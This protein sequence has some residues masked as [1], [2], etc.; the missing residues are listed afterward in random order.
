MK[1]IKAMHSV[2]G[3]V[4]AVLF[5]MW[6]ATG[7]V[8]IYHPYPRLDDK[9]QNHLS[10]TVQ[11]DSL[12]SLSYYTDSLTRDTI[13]SVSISQRLG[14]TLIRVST[15]DSA[16]TF[17]SDTTQAKHKVTFSDV[18]AVASRWVDAAPVR[19][20]TLNE[21]TQWVLYERYERAMPIYKFT[22]DDAEGHQLFISGKT[23][24]AQ[25]LTTCS[26]RIW[27][28]LGAIP[29]KF[30]Y[31]CIRKDVDLWK[32]VIT[33]G[34]IICLL[35]ALTGFM[36]GLSIQIRSCRRKHRLINPFKKPV[37]RWHHVIGL[38]FG[39]FIIGWGISGSLAMQKVPKWL[40]P[41][42]K[43]YSMY[44]PDIWEGD[45]L[46]LQ[47][48]RL[49]YRKVLKA[50]PEVKRIDLHVVGNKP[51]YVVIADS[52]EVYIDASDTVPQPLEVTAKSVTDAMHR[53]YG[54][55]TPVSVQL[56]TEYDEY[57]MA[58]YDTRPPLPVYK[59]TVADSD[60]STYYIG[61]D[62]DY[63]RYFNNNKKA[64]KWLFGALHYLNIKCIVS[65]PV[66]WHTCIW[67]LCFAGMAVSFTGIVLGVR[68]I[69]RKSKRI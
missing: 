47:T 18:E 11:T 51:V 59:V 35:A 56:M 25:Q 60:G 14:Q 2:T 20:D 64:R 55:E 17:C 45:S 65:H 29:H 24:E 3:T 9:L 28:W 58:S 15:A 33:T 49:D 22:Y 10:E 31:P 53:L 23:G 4:I 50:Y 48:Y 69:H 43:E 7:L 66:L 13:Q 5:F 62:T 63:C 32:T 57:Y 39:I 44:A 12:Q 37:Y 41:Y 27:S 19:V 61:T 6:F 67:L 52:N 42:D 46:P 8:L 16:Y 38:V 30:Y 54:N 1:L 68:Y 36:H 34:G 26:Q 40:V 21:R